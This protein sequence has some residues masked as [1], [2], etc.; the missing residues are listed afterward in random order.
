[1]ACNNENA[2][3]AESYPQHHLNSLLCTPTSGNWIRREREMG[4]GKPCSQCVK[5][6]APDDHKLHDDEESLSTQST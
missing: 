6:Q 4:E 5:E 1:M 2:T 3:A